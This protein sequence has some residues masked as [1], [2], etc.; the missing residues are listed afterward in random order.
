MK[1]LSKNLALLMLLLLVG[2]QAFS[3]DFEVNG[4]Y[5]DYDSSNQAAIVTF[6]SPFSS[7]EKYSGNLDIPVSVSY[8]GRTLPVLSIGKD[9]FR[10]CTEL[11]SV[12]LPNGLTR[13][14]WYAFNGCTKI[15]KIIIPETVTDIG[16]NAFEGCS[17]MSEIDIPDNVTYIQEETF[18]GCANLTSVLLPVNLRYINVRAFEGCSQ[19]Q[20]I[21]IPA[22]TTFI[23]EDAFSGCKHL[24]TLV[25]EDNIEKIELRVNYLYGPFNKCNLKAIYLGRPVNSFPYNTPCLDVSQ[26][27]L[28]S[29]GSNFK[30][31]SLF[32]DCNTLSTIYSFSENPK[33]SL[34]S[35]SN[36]TY[37]NSTL[38]IPIGTKDRYFEVEGWKNFFN[39]QEMDVNDMWDGK[40]EPSTGDETKEKCEKP[41]IRYTN[42]KLLFES[43][44]E[45]AICQS[46]ITDSDIASYSGNEIQLSATYNISV[47]A[48]K[49]GFDNSD[50]VTATLCWIDEDPKTEG[51]ESGVAQ[52]RANAVLIQSHDGMVSVEGVNDGMDIAVYDTSGQMVGSGKVHSNYSSIATNLKRGSVA[53]VRIGDKSV[54]IVMK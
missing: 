49:E 54:K 31:S 51:I 45:G 46:A 2:Q 52:V 25:F 27:E 36:K 28:I 4:I 40:G 13:I 5:Y 22:A 41:I 43:A 29:I 14:D 32:N 34:F 37:L 18:K 10:S 48:S 20:Y 7:D 9:A 30:S 16:R 38:Y 1:R 26:V 39:I 35:F 12:S 50:V 21:R 19:L 47:Y 17:T 42:G 15:S 53:I 24:E 8:N 11:E 23:D 33:E 3:Y 6:R 44:T